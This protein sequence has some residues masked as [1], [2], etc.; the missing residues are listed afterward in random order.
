MSPTFD[1]WIIPHVAGFIVVASSIHAKWEPRWWV[2]LILW[3]A[4]SVGWECI[5]FPLQ[6]AYPETWVVMESPLNAWV[7]DPLSNGVGWLIGALIGRWSKSR[8]SG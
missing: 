6:R 8:A 2:H 7:V 5:E 3:L 1:W 4:L